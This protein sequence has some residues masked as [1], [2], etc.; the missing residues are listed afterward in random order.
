MYVCLLRLKHIPVLHFI[1]HLLGT[2]HTSYDNNCN[3]FI[4][5]DIKIIHLP[6]NCPGPKDFFEEMCNI[7]NHLS[8]PLATAMMLLYVGVL[9]HTPPDDMGQNSTFHQRG[10]ALYWQVMK[11]DDNKHRKCVTRSIWNTFTNQVFNH[12][13]VNKFIIFWILF[14][15]SKNIT[16]FSSVLGSFKMDA[17]VCSKYFYLGARHICK[18]AMEQVGKLGQ[19]HTCPVEIDGKL[20]KSHKLYVYCILARLRMYTRKSYKKTRSEFFCTF[21]SP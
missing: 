16:T 21:V 12:I 11:F 20:L 2:I 7:T 1:Q 15:R 14:T 9:S 17:H 3:T 5:G 10:N 18:P 6:A 4:I 8:N 19:G 13:Q